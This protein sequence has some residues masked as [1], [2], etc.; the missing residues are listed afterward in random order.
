VTERQLAELGFA[1][2]SMALLSENQL[3][4]AMPRVRPHVVHT[5]AGGSG[6]NTMLGLALLGGRAC[7]T[8]CVGDDEFGELYRRSLDAHGVK[9]N[10]GTGEGA[11]G[12]SLILVTPDAQRTMCTHLGSSR[13]LSRG[14]I[15]L[16]DL[17]ASLMLYVTAYLWDTD[18]Q[19]EAVLYAMREARHAGVP[20]A[21]SLS[22]SFCVERHKPDM[23]RLV[24][25]HVD[26][27]FGNA[28]EA[29]ALTDTASADEAVQVLMG[30]CDTAVVTM[31]VRGALIGRCGDVV[32]VPACPV[33]AVDTTG[34][35]DMYAA[36]LLRGLTKGLPLATA[37]QLAAYGAAQ[38]VGKLG[39]RLSSLDAEAV[40]A[41]CAGA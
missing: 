14:D 4:G 41:I 32:S 37:G 24:R 39:P 27:L 1:K 13:C 17:R 21:L 29:Q 6:A 35:G 31:D 36:G 34:A 3:A 5:E 22:D 10:L 26:V 28:D 11:T 19:K 33:T 20:V 12:V 7:Y 25:D 38:V 15:D 2:G 16:A 9:A 23:K 40:A 8:S 30:L 18:N